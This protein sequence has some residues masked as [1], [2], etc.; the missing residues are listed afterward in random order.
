MKKTTLAIMAF[1][2]TIFSFSQVNVGTGTT[3]NEEMPIEPYYKFSYSQ[4]IYTAAEINASGSITGIKYT[5]NP[6][7]TL[8]NSDG[9]E[10]WLGHTT[11]S[12]HS[13]DEEGVPS[14]VDISELTQV[15]A[16]TVSVVDQVVD[17]VFETPFEYNG[18]DNLMIAVNETSNV[19]NTW[20]SSTHDFYCTL[21]PGVARGIVSYNDT[22]AID[23]SNPPVVNS[24]NVRESF[25]NITLEG[26]AQ[27]CP[28]PDPAVVESIDGVQVSFLFP[29]NDLSYEFIPS[30]DPGVEPTSS[31][32][33]IPLGP[34]DQIFIDDENGVP[35]GYYNPSIMA[36]LQPTT[37]Y[38]FYLRTVCDGEYSSWVPTYFT[39]GCTMFELPFYESFEDDSL[40]W[41][42]WSVEDLSP[43]GANNNLSWTPITSNPVDGTRSVYLWTID[44]QGKNDDYLISPQLNLSGNDR[45]KFSVMSFPNTDDVNSMSVLLS[46]TGSNPE[47][48]TE[49]LSETTEYPGYW[50]E[51]NIDLSAYSGPVYVAFY[52]PP[53]ST[54][55]HAIYLDSITFEENPE[56]D[57][58]INLGINSITNNSVSFSWEAVNDDPAVFESFET[59]LVGY[60]DGEVEPY[61]EMGD[62]TTESNIQFENINPGETYD[63]I[64]R[65]VCVNGSV[66]EWAT[67]TFTTPPLGDICDDPII[68]EGLPFDV[69]DNTEN[70]NDSYDG[71]IGDEES[72]GA[73]QSYLNGNDV[74]YSYYAEYD[75]SVNVSMTPDA[76]YSAIVVYDSCDSIGVSCYAASTQFSSVDEHNFDVELLAG[77]TYIFAIST[78]ASP[79]TVGYD[80]SIVENTCTQPVI[81][82]STTTCS[83]DQYFIDVDVSDL[84]SSSQYAISDDQG[85]EQSIDVP[86]V[87]TFGPYSGAMPVV[88]SAIGDDPNCDQTITVTSP[89]Q[90]CVPI[91]INCTAGDGFVGLVIADI[92]NSDSGCSPDGYGIFPELTTDLAQ[93]ATYPVTVTT[94]YSN[95]YIRAWVDFNDDYEYSLD[96]LIIDNALIATVGTTD[97]E[98]IIPADANLGTHSMRFKANWNASVPDDACELTS[99]GEV[100]DYFVTIVES[101]S[102]N[103]YELEGLKIYPNPV[104]GD[105][106]TI[107]SPIAGDKFINLF[108]INGRKVLSTTL[109]GDMLNISSFSAGFY[110]IEVTVGDS[111]KVSKLVIE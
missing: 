103:D 61:P 20:D 18:T 80:L 81:T 72:C 90:A 17:I 40:T 83:D 85:N 10:V 42:C 71:P 22:A 110:M 69:T 29:S 70:Y 34:N 26:I 86:S 102:T 13:L 25:A 27:S 63:F 77:Q 65:T 21:T 73:S 58:P 99:Y 78:W 101:L 14:W 68:I 33:G 89:C 6:E 5:A 38:V 57:Y 53:T 84:G 82:S 2:F 100:E 54:E 94:G 32:S 59:A 15:F 39:T 104:N 95:Q 43:E 55:G 93:G 45:L 92:D 66:S 36:G 51:V 31:T 105:F 41:E 74:F 16:G 4:V 37:E 19:N 23:P 52:V 64:V 76:T 108:D 79:Q 107:K 8:A 111:K 44:N 98:A 9:W 91:G 3:L 106:V 96:E 49:V 24:F 28:N 47:D 46:T 12:S 75:M 97:I 60:V 109:V 67:V 87:L 30:M 50:T 11:L 88:I 7:T 35:V 62:N 56:C 1:L 48:F